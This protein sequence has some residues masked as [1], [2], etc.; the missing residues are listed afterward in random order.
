MHEGSGKLTAYTVIVASLRGW[1]W[2]G[3]RRSGFQT[4]QVVR[5]RCFCTKEAKLKPKDLIVGQVAEM[6][7]RMCFIRSCRR[8]PALMPS[9]C[10]I[11]EKKF[12]WEFST[13]V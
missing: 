3:K 11:K 1:A 13:T 8:N 10:E 4:C 6:H 7:F 9:V 12:L 2:N 5:N